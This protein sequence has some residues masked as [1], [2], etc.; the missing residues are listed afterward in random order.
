MKTCLYIPRLFLP[1]KE[2]RDWCVIAGDRVSERAF[3]EAE[4][5][6]A[7]AEP[8]AYRMIVPEAYRDEEERISEAKENMFVSL[9][10]DWLE[11]LVRGL[12]LVER[13]LSKDTTRYGLVAAFDLEMFTFGGGENSPVR[14]AMKTPEPLADFYLKLREGAPIEMPH[15]VVLYRDPKDKAMRMLRDEDLERVYDYKVDGGRLKGYFVPEYFAEVADESFVKLMGKKEPAFFVAEGNAS[16]VAAKRHWEKLKE[17]L[18]EEE[19]R[20]HPARYFLAEFVNVCDPAVTLKPVHRLVSGV[21]TEAFLDYFSK[22]VPCTVKDRI[23]VLSSA[24]PETVKKADET[25]SAFLAANTGKCEYFEHADKLK[26]AMEED[27]AG[28]LLQG[29][30][31][32]ELFKELKNGAVYPYR[33]FCLDGARYYVEAREISYD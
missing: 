2:R 13:K 14:P 33:S 4:E 7:A 17:T 29:I 19:R 16:A 27:C 21:E 22:N 8:T 20:R 18:S 30:D 28:V 5:R 32:E 6:R 10:E 1:R 9:E 23:A 15:A 31:K 24:S 11:K 25:I 12:I 26:K 3:W